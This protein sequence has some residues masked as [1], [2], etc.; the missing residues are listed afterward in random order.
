MLYDPVRK[1]LFIH[2]WKTGGESVVAA[3]RGACPAYFSNRYL[4][5][6]I[7]LAP[8]PAEVLLD[9]RARLV[10]GQHFT[11]Q[12]ARENMPAE[13]FD[14]AFKFT[15]VR[16]PWDWQVS[17]YAY[18]LQTEAHGQHRIIHELGSFENYVRYQHEQRAPSQCSFVYDAAGTRL[19]DFVGRFETMNEDF[20]TICETIGL[21]AQ[22][23]MLNVSSRRRDWRSYYTDETRLLVEDLFQDD[24]DAFGYSWDG[25]GGD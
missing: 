21:E 22:L 2:V 1:F 23:P 15:F 6:A 3:L 9:W 17:N 5:K 20:R 19:I 4:N 16:N 7:R 18:G 14:E 10:C 12:Q 11:A 25:R 24:L 8:G 13:A